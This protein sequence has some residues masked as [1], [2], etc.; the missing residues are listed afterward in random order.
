MVVV[1][2]LYHHQEL[3]PSNLWV[4]TVFKCIISWCFLNYIWQWYM[5]KTISKCISSMGDYTEKYMIRSGNFLTY[6]NLA[7]IC[8]WLPSYFKESQTALPCYY[9]YS[10]ITVTC[11]HNIQETWFEGYIPLALWNWTAALWHSSWAFFATSRE[12]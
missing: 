1:L 6:F 10:Q 2:L 12:S 5:V 3:P 9:F 8:Y 4:N 7:D 11:S